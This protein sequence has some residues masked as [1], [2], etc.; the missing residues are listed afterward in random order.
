MNSI[1][2]NDEIQKAIEPLQ[3]TINALVAELKRVT[4]HPMNNVEQHITKQQLEE[5][6]GIKQSTQ[7]KLRMD[8]ENGLPYVRPAGAKI[9][10]YPVNE[11]NEWM[12]EWR[13]A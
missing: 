7:A 11:I 12:R 1:N 9:V 13:A 2:I 10:L 5:L 6:Y 4:L 3:N 8:K